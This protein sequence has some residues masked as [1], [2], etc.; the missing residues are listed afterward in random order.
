MLTVANRGEGGGVK[1]A[2]NIAD[3]ICERS[4]RV[5]RSIVPYEIRVILPR[6]CVH[7][8]AAQSVHLFRPRL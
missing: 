3:V 1:F 2:K 6:C 4:H 7:R 5:V 8:S